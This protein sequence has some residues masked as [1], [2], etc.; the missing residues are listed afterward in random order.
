MNILAWLTRTAPLLLCMPLFAA[1]LNLTP[2]EFERLGVELSIPTAVDH[3]SVVAARAR[4]VIP[5]KGEHI[6]TSVQPGLLAQLS[7]GVGD[8]VDQGQVLATVKSPAFLTSQ[9]VY[10]D[11]FNAN[12][13][14]QTQLTRDQQLYGEGIIS[15]RR[16]DDT[17][18][19]SRATS[20]Q[21]GEQQS[22]LRLSGMSDAEITAL[23]SQQRFADQLIVRAPVAG[24]VLERMGML[25]EQVDSMQ[26]MY[27]I[28]D[29]SRLWLDI[30]V[31]QEKVADV[32]IGMS[33]DVANCV[34][35]LPAEVMA[36]GQSVDPV[37]QTVVVRAELTHPDHLLKPGQFVSVRIVRNTATDGTIDVWSVPVGAVIRRDDQCHVFVRTDA[38]FEAREVTVVSATADQ[39]YLDGDLSTNIR[40]AVSGV[41]AL[42][43]IWANQ[44]DSDN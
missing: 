40:V 21:L 5:P 6:V 9:R 33:V 18:A 13:L 12:A 28:G 31:P 11:A 17:E 44:L 3:I 4:V 42:K 32:R 23:E 10:V 8:A 24:V 15:K 22:L 43:A 29:L 41:S 39:A 38:G 19:H 1:E 35:A 27:R 20:A 16:L 25:G 14:A 36:V 2:Q 34:V 26:P 30:Q 37:S 7:V